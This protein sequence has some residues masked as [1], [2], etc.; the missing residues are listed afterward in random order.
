MKKISTILAAS[1]AVVLSLAGC[2]MGN[3]DL[4][5][6]LKPKFII[7]DPTTTHSTNA[8]DVSWGDAWAEP[9]SYTSGVATYSF[10][11][12]G[13]DAWAAGNPAGQSSFKF[14]LSSDAPNTN[15]G[16][17]ALALN[18]D[19]V[20][21]TTPGNSNISVTGLVKG[22]TYTISVK[23]DGATISAKIEGVAAAPY[24]IINNNT[25]NE[26]TVA[27]ETT[28]TYIFT[29]G[30]AQ[31]TASFLMYD[32]SSVWSSGSALTLNTAATLVKGKNT[33]MTLTTTASTTYMVTVDT[34]TATAPTVTVAEKP[35]I[36]PAAIVGGQSYLGIAQG[37]AADLTYTY[38]SGYQTSSATFT[39]D[40]T[41]G[42]SAGDNAAAYKLQLVKDNWDTCYGAEITPSGDWTACT[43]LT[44][45]NNG[46]AKSLVSGKT[47]KISIRTTAT[48]VECKIEAVN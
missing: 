35:F 33:A 17:T 4:T 9:L 39:Y 16:N 27:T 40:G 14:I 42:W 28:Y 19:Y 18:S 24:Y 22:N 13:T 12:D 6:A 5:V 37:T 10:T 46:L 3:P 30:T 7:G 32:S 20:T 8:V 31:T 34:T 36:K 25:M 47:Y 11:Y 29:T 21:V 2:T 15:W 26:M 1:A 23:A 41:D 45:Y 44:G 38:D 43:V 48:T